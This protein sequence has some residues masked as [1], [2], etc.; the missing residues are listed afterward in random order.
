MNKLTAT[1]L[2]ILI[3][4]AAKAQ[5][6]D[7][8]GPAGSGSFGTDIIHLSNGNFVVTDPGYDEGATLN[9]GAVYLY[10]GTSFTPISVLKGSTAEDR[11]GQVIPLPNGNFLVVTRT[12]DNGAAVNAGAVTLVNGITGFSGVVSP[13]NSLVGSTTNDLVGG[14]SFAPDIKV[15]PNG[16]FV[17][18]SSSWDNGSIVNAGAVTFV[19]GSTGISGPV[20]SSNSLVG[21]HTDDAV[22]N[23]G[24]IVLT[25]GNFVVRSINWDK[26]IFNFGTG[27]ATWVNGNT[28]ITGPVSS[29]NSLVGNNPDDQVGLDHT[30]TGIGIYALANGNYVVVCSLCDIGGAT[31]AGTV[32]WGNGNTGITGPVSS[33]N[34]L[35]GGTNDFIGAAGVTALTN[36]N[37]VV[38]SNI[39]PGGLF[40]GA[41]TW[42]NGATGTTGFVSS[43]NSLVGP[44]D[45]DVV[46]FNTIA[47]SNGNYV[48]ACSTCD[49][50][51]NADAGAVTWGNGATGINGPV[52]SSNSLV[53]STLNDVVGNR[54]VVALSNGNY[55]VASSLWNNGAIADAGAVTWADGSVGI[56]GTISS[57]NSLVGGTANNNVGSV[58]I[59]ALPN[60]N[61]VVNSPNWDNG[62][63]ANIGAITWGN[64][65]TGTTGFVSSSNSLTGTA[66]NDNVGSNAI[67]VLANGNYVV[68]STDWDNGAIGNAGAVTWGNGATGITGPVSISNSLVGSKLNDVVG[69]QGITIL[70]N[71]NYLVRSA[72]WDNGNIVNAS[73]VTWADGTTGV[74]GP[75]TSA[76]SLIG[77][78]AS[79][80]IGGD[81]VG[82]AGKIFRF[83]NGNYAI[84]SGFWDNGATVNAGATTWGNASVPLT[85]FINSCNSIIGGNNVTPVIHLPDQN[86]MIAGFATANKIVVYNPSGMSLANS[87]DTKTMSIAGSRPVAIIAE[88]NCR[89]I[90]SITPNGGSPVSGN[91]TAKAWIE[92]N[93]PTHAGLPFVARHY[94]ITPATNPSTATGRV[95]LYFTQQEFTDFNN[96]SGSI[97]NL[98]TGTA[99]AIGKSNLRI[100]KYAGTSNDATGLPGSYTNGAA[101]IDPA[102][103]DIVF[104]NMLSRWE[105]SFN[106]SGFSGFIV[107]TSLSVL[108]LSLLE[109][110]GRL[111]NNNGLLNWKTSDEQNTASFDIERSTDGRSYITVGNVAAYNTAG[112]HQYNYT[113]NNITS[114]G[115]PVVYYRLK[116][117]DI[118][119]QFTY[120]RIVAL[121]IDNSGS[122]VLLY[123]NPVFNQ[124]NVTI[125]INKAE[126][127]QSRI[128]DNTGRVVKQQ[129]WN[130]IAGSS[131]LS[132][133]VSLLAKGMYYLELKGET[134]NERRQFVKQ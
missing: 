28:G 6:F 2:A 7:I 35:T 51:G 39:W 16:N 130:L 100:G 127:I 118:D 68:T 115:V 61:Y 103:A 101:I 15:L 64:G 43:S 58:T 66:A 9:V 50:D 120:S 26:Q 86:L 102:D 117:K 95:T 129:Q 116:Q 18:L 67:S 72:E 91:I 131:S 34:S 85:G 97:L 33:S 105:V 38:K 70:A 107:Q 122:I 128:V 75:I 88:S 42:G 111:L 126:K 106:V 84:T 89:I 32:T 60:G 48:V 77:A 45:N 74:I 59:T 21:S 11:V 41:A 113:D 55:V 99:D 92:S 98:P 123:P 53:G 79:D 65:A 132:V 96:H 56:T 27:A 82:N 78:T 69:K 23:G 108:P 73:A 13:A 134:I 29:S 76:N 1:C 25:N 104:N 31:D 4:T 133:D 114:L 94:E 40:R 124:A 90:A 80:F 46:G 62:S 47:L 49:I 63:P 14:D 24:I 125:T 57:S 52:S 36:G 54:G 8:T 3:A 22:G 17:V 20:S 119:G 30:G 44:N 83:S 12:W 81:I 87:L 109:F 93:V 110:N 112:N 121:S 10:S 5:S 37:Y 19:N 71:G